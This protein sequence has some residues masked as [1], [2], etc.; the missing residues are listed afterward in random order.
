MDNQNKD[1]II[2]FGNSLNPNHDNNV[3][4]NDLSNNNS[5]SQVSN[6]GQQVNQSINTQVQQAP[7]NNQ[8]INQ[9]I[10]SQMQTSIPDIG[11][12]VNQN[13]NTQVQQPIPNSNQSV[14]YNMNNQISNN[15]QQ[16]NQSD[17]TQVGQP[18]PNN[19]QTEHNT[20]IVTINNQEVV[21][22]DDYKEDNRFRAKVKEET[23][24]EKQNKKNAIKTI[25]VIAILV[26]IVFGIIK[27]AN[28]FLSNNA[29]DNKNSL[30]FVSN[31]ESF[32]T[33]AKSLVR[34]DELS[35]KDF[36]YAPSCTDE[37]KKETI[38]YLSKILSNINDNKISPFGGEYNLDKSYVKVVAKQKNSSCEYDYYI[39]LT[40]N[41]YYIGS[42]DNPILSTN[43]TKDEVKK[44]SK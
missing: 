22:L 25:M 6:N 38:I 31:A 15:N 1:E 18:I 26:L 19:N 41:S 23:K 16:I 17:N 9:N 20:N 28:I 33:D 40:D 21:N 4:F 44:Y 8:S 37:N 43:L 2:Q 42:G 29:I 35:S 14:N 34:K 7:N 5:N 30:T 24:E 10:N 13:V 32:I 3:K 11:Q 27:I 36:N 12:Q 39:Y